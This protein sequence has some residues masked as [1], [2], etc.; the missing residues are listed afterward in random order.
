MI[1]LGLEFVEVMPNTF[2][3]SLNGDYENELFL[4]I[5][6]DA[7]NQQNILNFKRFRLF[8]RNFYTLNIEVFNTILTKCN[9]DIEEMIESNNIYQKLCNNELM[10]AFGLLSK[11]SEKIK[12][13]L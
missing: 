12:I 8:I 11:Q 10:L 13:L 9:G 6:I 3:H 4:I 5:Q 1:F 7:Y 2:K